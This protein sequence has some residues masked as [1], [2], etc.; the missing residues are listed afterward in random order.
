MKD[1]DRTRK[2][3]IGALR[4][5]LIARRHA[6]GLSVAAAADAA[7]LT[8]KQLALVEADSVNIYLDQAIPLLWP[9]EADLRWLCGLRMPGG[10]QPVP[11]L[12]AIDY[13]ARRN[14]RNLR[15][16][17]GAGIPT[18][19]REAWKDRWAE[20]TLVRWESGEY[21]RLDL[22]RLQLIAD[23]H[24]IPLYDLLTDGLESFPT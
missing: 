4:G 15:I 18:A 10:L 7:G 21:T 1:I 19:N 14:M 8:E 2:E 16:G 11:T 6:L 24:E 12:E 22:F 13:T 20:S 5:R 23:W 9:Y 3:W 17:R